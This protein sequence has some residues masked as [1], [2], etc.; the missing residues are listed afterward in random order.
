M[1]SIKKIIPGSTPPPLHPH[2]EI[3]PKQPK[4]A[5]APNFQVENA[6]ELSKSF[7]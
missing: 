3:R 7:R 2:L 4:L 5:G 6:S 1:I